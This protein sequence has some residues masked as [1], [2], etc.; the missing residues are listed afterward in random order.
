MAIVSKKKLHIAPVKV[1][2]C[3]KCHRLHLMFLWHNQQ[4]LGPIY[5][6]TVQITANRF[7][8]H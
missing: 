5:V 6:I 1:K 3:E 8:F 7:C 2:K 4:V